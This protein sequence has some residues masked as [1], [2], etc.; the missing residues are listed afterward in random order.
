MSLTTLQVQRADFARSRIVESPL[1]A[2]ADGQILVRIDK[3]AL[4]ANNVTYALA[5]DALGYWKFFPAEE[6]W[7][8]VPVW[9]FGDVVATRT[10]DIL[11]GERL[12]GYWPMASHVVLTPSKVSPRGFHEV[13]PHRQGL[14]A[15]YNSYARTNNDPPE[16][17]A[18][19]DRRAILFPLYATSYILCDYLAD[20]AVFGAQDVLISSISSKTSMGL[21]KL[22]MA[23]GEGRPRVIGLTSPANVNYVRGLGVCDEVATYAEI[24]SLDGARAAVFVDMAGQGDVVAAVHACYGANLKASVAVGVT[25]W[26]GRRFSNKQGPA[27]SHTFFFAPAQLAKRDKDWGPG[28]AMR[29]AQK[30]C[31]GLVSDLSGAMTVSHEFGATA[32]ETAFARLV[33][34]R[35]SPKVGIIASLSR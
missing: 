24:S 1:P 23:A 21:G 35:Q 17:K 10:S 30:A 26:E 5:G 32:T 4:T 33:A 20:N 8:V 12:W 15:A 29:R 11:V 28:E 9:G 6:P 3:F 7:G 14:A 13:S 31:L 25:H 22:L 27:T 34:G 19:E 18:L 2:P 16:L